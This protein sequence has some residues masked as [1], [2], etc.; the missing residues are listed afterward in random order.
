M[1]PAL[2]APCANTYM[3]HGKPVT[4]SEDQ[5]AGRDLALDGRNLFI[6]G[7]PGSGKSILV[8]ALRQE[9]SKLKKSVAYLAPTGLAALNIRGSTIHRFFKLPLKPIAPDWGSDYGKTFKMRELAQATDILV[10]DEISMVRSDVFTAMDMTLRAAMNTN[11][12]FG[13]KQL[14]VVGD[15]FQIQPVVTEVSLFG[16]L[17]MHFGGRLSCHTH[18][19]EGAKIEVVALKTNHRQKDDSRFNLALNY[20][21]HSDPTGLMLINEMATI[22]HELRGTII[23]FTNDSAQRVNYR[24]LQALEAKAFT[25]RAEQQGKAAAPVDSEIELKVG[26]RVMLMANTDFFVNGDLGEVKQLNG[27]SVKV[28]LDRGPT[29]TVERYTW[30]ST[31]YVVDSNGKL[32]ED[33]V[34]MFKQLPIRLGWAITAHKS[35][36]QTLDEVTMLMDTRPFEKGQLYV[37]LSRARSAAGL[38]LCRPL[39][40]GDLK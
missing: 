35:Q 16:W 5:A 7:E 28:K 2:E 30:D 10:I 37:A 1:I 14:I 19:W 8:H 31:A 34:G 11:K 18:S 36:G 38:T 9:F 21:R 33:T 25:Y 27:D 17:D 3:I 22:S 15:F 29:V 24:Q 6:T 20:I 32:V 23:T 26:A 40:T 4:L 39:D 12:P 13:G